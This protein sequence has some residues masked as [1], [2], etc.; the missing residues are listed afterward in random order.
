MG[1][2]PR[3]G[4]G[5]GE[6]HP[7]RAGFAGLAHPTADRGRRGA[8]LDF[9]HFAD[10][11]PCRASCCAPGHLASRPSFPRFWSGALTRQHARCVSR[12]GLTCEV[13]SQIGGGAVP[14]DESRGIKRLFR[15]ARPHQRHRRP[16]APA[17]LQRMTG[18]GLSAWTQCHS[19]SL[20]ICCVRH[21]PPVPAFQPRSVT[22][23]LTSSPAWSARHLTAPARGGA[24]ATALCRETPQPTLGRVRRKM[25]PHRSRQGTQPRSPCADWASVWS[26]NQSG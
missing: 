19:S 2:L 25:R 14:N 11:S 20:S 26:R 10:P 8:D 21:L 17:R 13:Q 9:R 15:Y 16:P 12:I 6:L 18:R 3:L 23:R 4:A 1:D 24:V 7:P 22:S 5:Q